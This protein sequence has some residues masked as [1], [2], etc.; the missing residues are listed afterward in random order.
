MKKEGRR[1]K[2]K[3]EGRRQ[4]ECHEKIKLIIKEK[5]L[6]FEFS[7]V[8]SVFGSCDHAPWKPGVVCLH[9]N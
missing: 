1:R 3:K 9:E 4:K 7:K 5:I 2:S 8:G 6:M